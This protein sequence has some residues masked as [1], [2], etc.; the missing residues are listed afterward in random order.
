MKGSA[1]TAGI[2]AVLLAL[3]LLLPAACL[4]ESGESPQGPGLRLEMWAEEI[5]PGKAVVIA[6]T[7]PEDGSY[8]LH[9]TDAEG[10]SVCAAAE[11]R[12]GKAGLN[13]LY[14]NGTQGGVPAPEGAW[15]LVLEASGNTAEIPVT[16]GPM[17]PTIIGAQAES[18]SAERGEM[19]TVSFFA[20]EAGE[21][22]IRFRSTE[23]ELVMPAEDVIRGEGSLEIEAAAPPGE[24]RLVMTLKAAGGTESDPAEVPVTILPARVRTGYTPG[25]PEPES[26]E[27]GEL[28]YWNLPMDITDTRGV[29]KA[30]TAPIT[31]VDS[32]GPNAERTQV[33]IRK[34]PD[35]NSEGI[36]VVTCVS[37]GVRVLER[38]GEWTRIECYSSSFHNSA[39]LNWNAL[40]R[41]YVPTAYLREVTPNQEMGLVVDKLTQRL[42]VF[43]N[44]ELLSTLL[45]STGVANARQ[46]YNETRSGEFLLISKV[47]G[48]Q[49]DNMYCPRAIR[50]NSGDLLHEV[51]FIYKADGVSRSYA[52]TEPRLGTKASHGCVRVQQK[53]TPEGVNQAWFWDHYVKNTK[54]LIWED[55]QG[56]QIPVPEDDT[57]IYR[58]P[59]GGRVYHSQD[60]CESVKNRTL[61]AFSYGEL[62]SEEYERF[63]PC[64]WCAPPPRRS[65]LEEINARYA[66]GGDH[67]PVMTEARKT[68]PRSR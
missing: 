23:G 49:S 12:A 50:F 28:T 4:G 47:G 51:P 16:V 19:F 60:H 3:C 56:R 14:W 68:T 57:V 10:Q 8:S 13:T 54:I 2:T 11:D 38:A 36:G 59:R 67:D 45:V 64:E 40:V 62:E 43:R 7:L 41:G 58:D 9:L 31:V 30:L 26:S 22:D 63:Q 46:P 20:T 44:G 35:E 34:E 27:D 37:Q 24:S 48:F 6:V 33:I 5:R 15:R 17:A 61:A 32:G 52:T 53:P 1:C 21:M 65:T 18:G 55:W 29:W 25:R 42:Y 66:P 39:I